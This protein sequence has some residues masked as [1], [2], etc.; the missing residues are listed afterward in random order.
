[1]DAARFQEPRR[2]MIPIRSPWGDGEMAVLDFGDPG[3]PVDVVF[4]HANGFNAMTYR[5]VLAPL[6]ASLRIVAPDLRG[7][8]ATRLPASP[9]RRR[10]W[11]DFRDDLIALI[12]TFDGPP[13]TLSGH[14]MGGTS[15][16]LAAARRPDRV[17]NVVLLDP[18]IWSPWAAPLT[19][20]PGAS[21][22]LKRRMLIA[23][24]ALRRRAVFRSRAEAFKAYKG[25]GAFRGW[26]EIALADYVAGGFVE[27]PDGT[28]D[29]ACA[30]EWEAS[31][32]A[33]QANDAWGALSRL[34]RPVRV[35]RA[36]DSSPCNCSAEWFARRHPRHSLETVEGTHFFPIEQPEIAR[37]AIFEAAV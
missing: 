14:S 19:H 24:G 16:L 29:L 30:P 2:R 11:N 37:E 18:V 20:L 3:R 17:S 23:Q 12:D 21:A 28:V 13:L 1:M 36:T 27:R 5:S 10:S 31:N 25:R 33:A 4:A 6:S 15:V 26:P 9:G 35:I 7:H 34:D 32:F 8:G 22:W